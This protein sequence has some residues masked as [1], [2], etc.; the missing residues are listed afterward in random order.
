MENP[1]NLEITRQEMAQEARSIAA[2][3]RGENRTFSNAQFPPIIDPLP[4]SLA[5]NSREPFLRHI[6]SGDFHDREISNQMRSSFLISFFLSIFDK[7]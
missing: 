6:Q 2:S 7:T 3:I 1:G 5:S 4:A